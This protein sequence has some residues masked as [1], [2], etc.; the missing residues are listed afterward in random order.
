MKVALL[1][2]LLRIVLLGAAACALVATQAAA[3]EEPTR[4][5]DPRIAARRLVDE[6]APLTERERILIKRPDR[7]RPE[8]PI[9]VSVFG[10][11]LVLG[12]RYTLVGRYDQDKLLDFDFDD[13]DDNGEIEDAVRGQTPKDDQLRIN[14]TL[15]A[16]L[17][18][19]FTDDIS[20]Y[21]EMKVFYR[22]LVWARNASSRDSKI[23]ERGESWLYFGR[24]LG[25]PFG[26]QVGRQAFFD[27]RE[28]WWDQDLDAARLRLDG[29]SF[30]A[31]LAVAQEILPVELD[32]TS[33][34]PEVK[35]V[36]QILGN[37]QWEWSRRHRIGVYA[38]HRHDHSSGQLVIPSEP[39]PILPCVPEDE[40]PP[41]LPEEAREFFR[42]G[43]PDP[44]AP[45]DFE[46]ESDPDLTWFGVSASGRWKAGRGGRIHYWLDAAGVTGKE[47]STDYSG[48]TGKSVVSSRQ[49]HKVEG[50]GL[51]LGATWEVPVFGRPIFTAGYAYGSG[52][53][54]DVEERD[55]G[56]RQTGLQDNNDKFRGVVSFR[57]YGELLDPELANLHIVTA[58]V[59]TRFLD[60]S[61]IDLVY[62]HY[63]QDQATPFLRDI[64]FKR[65]PDGRHRHIGDEWDL[66]L[67]IEDFQPLEVKLVGSIFRAGEA[68]GRDEGDLAYLLSLRLRLNF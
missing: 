3:K 31:E 19:P 38:L 12:G 10:R 40:I 64:D 51:D 26:V 14:Q 57:Y 4:V 48:P 16:D 9:S 32:K 54:G 25:S 23:Y 27:D 47:T 39:D 5:I 22:N 49:R 55:R 41:N 63:R 21:V 46:D 66:I 67:G 8:H 11:P 59:G 60:K 36:L 68:F 44:I 56:F 34:D 42:S 17:F 28:W 7:H 50:F 30:H 33:I 6:Q 62:H 37:A 35:N 1:H 20:A 61:S 58:G 53:S 24:I 43:C 15:Q 45:V 65:D 52:R 18:Y 2:R 29:Q 13:L